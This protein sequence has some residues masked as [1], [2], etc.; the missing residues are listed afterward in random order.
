MIRVCITGVAGGALEASTSGQASGVGRSGRERTGKAATAAL[1]ALHEAGIEFRVHRFEHDPSHQGFALEAADALGFPA[2]QV[3][4]TLIVRTET[5]LAVAIVPADHQLSL[6]NV[7]AALGA[8]RAEMADPALAER[9]TGYVRGG[10]S[11]FGQRKRLPTVVDESATGL[12]T[13]M[14]SGGRRGLEIELRPADLIAV[15]S[16][17]VAPIAAHDG[18][19]RGQSATGASAPRPTH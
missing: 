2:E 9:T 8:K 12:A 19:S 14:V 5:G 4:K 10:I 3:F 16:A 18:G 13:M 15:L 6:K 11:P 1:Q 7:A 17:A